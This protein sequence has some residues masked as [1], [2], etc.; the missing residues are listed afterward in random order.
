M[1]SIENISENLFVTDLTTWRSKRSNRTFAGRSFEKLHDY[2]L[3]IYKAYLDKRNKQST[4]I[5]ILA[6]SQCHSIFAVLQ[7]GTFEY[8]IEAD[9][10]EGSC[11]WRWARLC[12]WSAFML[13]VMV[14]ENF[15][16]VSC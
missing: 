6:F 10:I 11:P 3:I 1:P 16:K 15:E 14:P 12:K 4:I 8:P 7:I 13:T 5:R 2:S 9:A